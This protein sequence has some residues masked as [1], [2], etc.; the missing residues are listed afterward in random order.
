MKK[1]LFIAMCIA[2]MAFSATHAGYKKAPGF[3]LTDNNGNFV[4]LSKLKGNLIIS[5]WASYCVP[6]KKEMPLLVEMEKKYGREKNL[7]LILI[8][9]DTNDT[10]KSAREKAMDTLDDIKVSHD[11]LMDMYHMALVK[12]NPAKSVPCT[13]LVNAAGNI[14]FSETGARDDTLTRLEKAV[15]SLR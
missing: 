9:V 15:L 13:F 10:G 3:A 12:Y 7:S 8:N 6:C 5:F 4:Y 14:V 2:L 11:F 1:T